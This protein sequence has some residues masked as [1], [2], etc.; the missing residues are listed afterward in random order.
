MKTEFVLSGMHCGSCAALIKE[1]LEETEGVER[2]DV[3]FDKGR[4][5]VE[6][7]ESAVQRATLQE[8]IHAL[9]LGYRA[10]IA[11]EPQGEG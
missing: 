9:D 7:D 2:A 8:K 4:A 11:G 1:T 10:T 5:V 3:S 6:Y